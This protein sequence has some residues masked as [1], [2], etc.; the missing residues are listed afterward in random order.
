MKNKILNITI[1]II[2]ILIGVFVGA[3]HEPWADEAQAWL[4]ARDASVFEILFNV[5]RYEGTPPIWHLLLKLLINLGYKYEYLYLISVFFSSFGVAIILF[6]LDIPKPLKILLPFTYFLLYEYTVKT[7]SYCLILPTLAV[8]ADIY[9]DRENKP[10]LYNFLL[11]FL[12]TIS[13]YTAIISGMLYLLEIYEIVKKSS[14]K[15]KPQ[16]YVREIIS[17]IVLSILYIFIIICVMP[18]PYVYVP[19]NINHFQENT[20]VTVFVYILF[21]FLEAFTL[22][23]EYSTISIILSALFVGLLLFISVFKNN[24][25]KIWIFVFIPFCLFSFLIRIATHH[26]GILFLTFLFCLYLSKETILEKNKKVVTFM[27]TVLFTIQIIWSINTLI[28]EIKYNYSAAKDVSNYIKTMNYQ[29]K[30]IYAFGYY[31]VAILPYFDENIF[32]NDRGGKTYYIWSSQNTDWKKSVSKENAYLDSDLNAMPDIIILHDVNTTNSY[33]NL[34]EKVRILENYKELHFE[35][36]A[37]FKQYS[38]DNEK[39]GYYV[40]ERVK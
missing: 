8:I 21:R 32:D 40:F 15:E 22:G 33:D 11:G 27:M 4:I 36:Q 17:V 1:L 9:K 7:R 28:P 10:I 14:Q 23:I 25:S 3:H 18:S 12:A 2:F 13:L 37:F 38:E 6:K 20:F 34:K 31:P 19:I 39:E 24:K 26:I 16:Y 35:G 5:E 30:K 29:E